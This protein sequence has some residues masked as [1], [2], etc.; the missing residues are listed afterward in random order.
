MDART[1]Q[2]LDTPAGHDR[3][4][5]PLTPVTIPATAR[6]RE[7]DLDPPAGHLDP[8]AWY[9]ATIAE[10][11]ALLVAARG[12]RAGHGNGRCPTD[13]A[14]PICVPCAIYVGHVYIA[15]HHK[16]TVDVDVINSA[17][18]RLYLRAQALGLPTGNASMLPLPGDVPVF[19]TLMDA[20]RTLAASAT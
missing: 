8:V 4:E 20:A 19:V 12:A 7:F 18:L 16:G 14:T 6:L 1:W 5:T 17:R 3:P 11:A 9:A 15:I 13:A 2:A 10:T